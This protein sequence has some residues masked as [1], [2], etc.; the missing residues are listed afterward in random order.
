MSPKGSPGEF[1]GEEEWT[2][3]MIAIILGTTARAMYRYLS[4]ERYPEVRMMKRFE[5]LFGWP[6][7]EQV[8]L[9]PWAGYDLRYSMVLRMVME[10]W[11][12]NN[13][14]TEV[15]GRLKCRFDSPRGNY[16]QGQLERAEREKKGV[17]KITSEKV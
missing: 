4:G 16:S 1:R 2:V 15:R 12:H 11:K 17:I 8:A 3:S 9:V 14:R 5:E 10:D 6:A 13:P 7:T